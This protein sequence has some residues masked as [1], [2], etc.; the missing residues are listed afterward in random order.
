VEGFDRRVAALAVAAV[1]PF[2]FVV[3]GGHAIS[4]NGIG[5]R[6]SHDVDLFTNRHDDAAG[7]AAAKAT[8]RRGLEAA[9]LVVTEHRNY[10][11]FYDIGVTDPATSEAIGLQLA[12]DYRAYPP[13]T[14]DIGPV[15]DVRDAIGSKVGALYGR[16]VARDF[17]DVY[18]ALRE[19][20]Y[21]K[22]QLLAFG[23]LH[24]AHPLDRRY[25]AQAMRAVAS[26]PPDDFADYGVDEPER[27]DIIATFL[28]WAEEI[29]PR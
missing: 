6:P 21:S 22:T 20:G 9:G 25:L 28:D 13:V 24:E 5:H 26:I 23:D 27:A 3:A 17:I 16:R 4:L 18:H 12:S 29:D 1:E 11:E 15:L 10:D 7:F 14:L 19:S 2:G 8:L